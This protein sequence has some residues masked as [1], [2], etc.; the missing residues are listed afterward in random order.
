MKLKMIHYQ[1]KLLSAR[2]SLDL[3]FAFE[4]GGSVRMRFLENKL[5]GEFAPKTA[6]PFL[7]GVFL[8]AALYVQRHTGI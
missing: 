8:N 5:H 2:P 7:A 3:G 1:S 4:G 6:A